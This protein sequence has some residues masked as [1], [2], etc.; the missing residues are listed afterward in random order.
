MD[1]LIEEKLLLADGANQGIAPA[2]DD[3]EE[4]IAILKKQLEN[5]YGSEEEYEKALADKG[6][7]MEDIHSYVRNQ[8]TIVSIY[9]EVTAGVEVKDEDVEAFYN[10]NQ[11][12]FQVSEQ[13]RA[14]HILVKDQDLAEELLERPRRER[15]LPTWPGSIPKMPFQ[16][17][18][19]IWASS[20]GDDGP[21]V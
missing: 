21:R 13:V 9:E 4:F 20:P 17:A 18:G 14:R 8:L 5:L 16:A 19:E 6:L 10:D 2:E 1:L 15:I 11:A 3:V 12:M 7:A